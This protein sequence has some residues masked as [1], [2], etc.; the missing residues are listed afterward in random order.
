VA[1]K[2][3]PLSV[4]ERRTFGEDAKRDPLTGRIYE[5]GHGAHRIP[6]QVALFAKELGRPLTQFEAAAIIR[7]T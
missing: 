4:L 1:I 3:E 5:R 2:D 6:V 7:N